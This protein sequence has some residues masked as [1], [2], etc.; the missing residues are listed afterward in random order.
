MS[1]QCTLRLVELV[2]DLLYSHRR[3][4]EA[5]TPACRTV[6][7]RLRRT[8]QGGRQH[9]KDPT[10]TRV[11]GGRLPLRRIP[12]GQG[13]LAL[14][15]PRLLDSLTL[16]SPPP[17]N[18]ECEEGIFRLS[19]SANV[20]RV[21]SD[22]ALCLDPPTDILSNSQLLKERFNA[23]GD[24]NLLTSNEYYDPHAVAGLLKQYLRELPVHLLTRELHA[25]FIQVIDLRNRRDRV[26]ALGRLVAQLPIEEYTLFR[27]LYVF[28]FSSARALELTLSFLT[29]LLV[30]RSTPRSCARL[31]TFSRLSPDLC[32]IAQNADVSK[33]NVRNL[34]IVFSPTLA[35][36]APLFTLLLAEFDVSCCRRLRTEFRADLF[37]SDSS[38]SP[39]SRKL[40]S[41]NLSFSRRRSKRSSTEFARTATRSSTRPVAPLSLW[42][43]I[44]PLATPFEVHSRA[45]LFLSPAN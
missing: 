22:L 45:L 28:F 21:R 44:L 26:N 37:R 33:M 12:G 13:A 17:Q 31:L 7:S 39:W 35:I 19:G 6:S 1:L 5:T 23:E 34:G 24:V 11:A 9:L 41:R 18:A 30:R 20:I 16:L 10:W 36:P 3:Q 14:L 8:A 42:K 27:F 32:I 43:A 15:E 38:S 40:V 25:E 29:A 2:A 4:R